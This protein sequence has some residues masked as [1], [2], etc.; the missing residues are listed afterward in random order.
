M[1]ILAPYLG[2]PL[3]R[4]FEGW[5]IEQI[6]RRLTSMGV[7]HALFAVS[8]H[9]EVKWPADQVSSFGGKFIGLQFKRP[10]AN[11]TRPNDFSRLR[12]KLSSPTNQRALVEK[13]TEIHYCLPTFV[14]RG[15]RRRALDHCLFWRPI[16]PIPSVAW[17]DNPSARAVGNVARQAM[18]WGELFESIVK[19][20][21]GTPLVGGLLDTFVARLTALEPDVKDRERQ[22]P[23]RL[24]Q[25]PVYVLALQVDGW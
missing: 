25:E 3:E 10:E 11:G 4:E 24:V 12:W 22:E 23:S 21:V 13:F 5:I 2:Y 7:A 17:Y 15:V 18:R 16:A 9:V 19:C 1:D 14:N 20:S 8:P 6:D